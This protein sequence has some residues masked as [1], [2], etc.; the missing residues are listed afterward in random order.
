M[1]FSKEVIEASRVTPVVVD[2]WAPWCGPCRVL[3]PVI[4][5]LAQENIDRWQLVK[6]NTEE[7]PEIAEQYAIRSIPNVKLFSNGKVIAEF[8][9]A[10]PKHQ[11]EAWLNEYLPTEETKQWE[12]LKEALEGLDATEQK[13]QLEAFLSE[14]PTHEEARH[15]LA[16]S[17]AFI[18]TAKAIE[19]LKD[20]KMAHPHYA[21]LQD[22]KALEELN[23]LDESAE[24]AVFTAL[25][26]AAQQLSQT[27]LDGA[28]QSIIKAVSMDKEVQDELPRR[29]GVAL[30]RLLGDHD[31]VTKKHR[32]TFDMWLY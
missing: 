21:T 12:E 30:F 16:K 4:E 23:G 18:K 14:Q 2:F 13:A 6:V 11:I 25:R 26:E 28:A 31:V 22:L 8:A 5:E 1:N 19:L 17:W 15:L 10:L 27:D 20:V 3:G 24:G 9:G 29:A 7:S 32:R